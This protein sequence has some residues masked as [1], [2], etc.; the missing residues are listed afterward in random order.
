MRRGQTL[1]V[2]GAAGGVGH[3]A[4]QLGKHARA[5]VIGTGSARNR[6]FV[7]GLGA[8]RYIDYTAQDV[9]EAASDVDVAF[10]TVGGETTKTLLATVREGGVLVVIAGE[11]PTADAAARGVRAELLIQRSNAGQLAELGELVAAGAVSVEIAG[12]FALQ[13]A[14]SAHELSEAGT[15]AG[16]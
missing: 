12:T 15:R 7:L 1:L 3:F 13:D 6:E 8:D 16:S 9:A 10:D 14:A 2:A 5:H 11:P 4:V